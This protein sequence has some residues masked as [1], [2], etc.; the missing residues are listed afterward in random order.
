AQKPAADEQAGDNKGAG[1]RRRSGDQKPPED[2]EE[3]NL[4]AQFGKFKEIREKFSE[5]LRSN[6]RHETEMC[7]AYAMHDDRSLTELL[8][9]DYTYVN[10]ELAKFYGVP[11]V[12]GSEMRRVTLPADSP[13]GGLITQGTMLIV[14]S[15]PTRTSPVKRGKFILDNVLG[16]PVP[17]PP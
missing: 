16:T 12:K 4:R 6:M 5:T 13:R 1:R 11:D 14:T 3:A 17:P 15:N 10:E 9:S 8:D 7:F 2:E